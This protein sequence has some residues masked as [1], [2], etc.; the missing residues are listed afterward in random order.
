MSNQK[1][2]IIFMGTPEFAVPGLRQLLDQPDFDVIAVY[3]QPDKAVGRKQI[4]TAS[5]IKQLAQQHNIPV[6]QPQKISEEAQRI[7]DLAPDLIVV[8]A[9]GKII[10]QTILDIPKYTCIN[11][12]ASLLPKYRGA[13]CLNAPILNGDTET[14]ITIMKMN[15]GLDTGPIIKQV[16]VQVDTNETLETLHDKLSI[17]GA[18]TLPGVLIDF[19]NGKIQAVPQDDS[20]ATYIGLIKK[21][22]GKIDWD[23]TAEEIE[24]MIRALNPWPGTYG[25]WNNKSIKIIKVEHEKIKQNNHKT[26]E[27]FQNNGQILIQCGQDSLVILKLQL[28]GKKAMNA[29]E[30]INGNQTFIGKIIQ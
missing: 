16:K 22:D 8:I 5:P 30:F 24:R 10:P 15:A 23:M 17:L 7:K 4:I 13:A 3:T 14:G 20:R 26:G 11:V 19:I 1:T 29:Q 2:K 25:E 9:Y 27:I 21:E 6:Y 28:E 18:N 12:H